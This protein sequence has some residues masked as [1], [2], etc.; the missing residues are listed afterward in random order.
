MQKANNGHSHSND[1][2]CSINDDDEELIVEVG[3]NKDM[4]Y[5]MYVLL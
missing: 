5:Q 1:D 2:M 4:L 3:N